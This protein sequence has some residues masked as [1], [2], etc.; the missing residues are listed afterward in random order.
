MDFFFGEN[1]RFIKV[2]VL[3]D[4]HWKEIICTDPLILD[5]KQLYV[6]VESVPDALI[7]QSLLLKDRDTFKI[8]VTIFFYKRISYKRNKPSD[9][10]NKPS[11]KDPGQFVY[12]TSNFSH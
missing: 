6:H 5:R 9:L 10:A 2:N 11:K 7:S 3:Q 4:P 12:K 8:C 1:F